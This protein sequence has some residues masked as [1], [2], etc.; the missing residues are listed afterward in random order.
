MAV[1]SKHKCTVGEVEKLHNAEVRA[2]IA[3]LAAA[4]AKVRETN[5]L[6]LPSY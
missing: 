3:E 1:G 6:F 5:D 4:A 2:L